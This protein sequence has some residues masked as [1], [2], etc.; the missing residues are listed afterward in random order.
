[1]YTALYFSYIHFK[2]DWLK[3]AALYWGTVARIVPHTDAVRDGDSDTVRAF[4]GRVS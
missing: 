3:L 2:N 1:M 4:E